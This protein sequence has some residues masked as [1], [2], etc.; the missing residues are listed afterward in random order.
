MAS[1]FARA[2]ALATAGLLSGLGLAELGCWLADGGAFPHVNFYVTDP[3][4]G[5][6]LA[7]GAT[8]RL[9]YA[10][11][12]VTSL[13]TNARGFRGEDWPSAPKDAVLVLG[14]SQVFG[15]G[16]EDGDTA[17]ARLAS[18]TG[19]TVLNA[20]TPTWG[21]PEYLAEARTLVPELHPSTVVVVLNVANDLFEADRPNA[22]RHA[23]WD[24]WAVRRETAPE[25]LA[26]FPGR[27]WLMTQSHAVFAARRWLTE[28]QREAAPEGDA[29]FPSE[30]TATDLL[31]LAQAAGTA[32][33]AGPTE[34]EIATK[35]Q[36]SSQGRL[37]G[38]LDLYWQLRGLVDEA[39]PDEDLALQAVQEHAQ[40]GD[41][42]LERYAEEG[43]SFPVTADALRKGA[44]LRRNL[45]PRLKA[46]AEAHPKDRRSA[47]ILAALAAEQASDAS[48]SELG[49]R[50]AAALEPTT[51]VEGF[52]HEMQVLC[53][54]NH[55]ELVIVALPVD[56]QVSPAEW[57]KYGKDPADP[58]LDMAGTGVLLTDIV[59]T[60]ERAG[61]RGLDATQA[62]AAAEPGAFLDGDFHLT[63]KGHAALADAIVARLSTPAPPARPRAGLPPGRSRVPSAGELELAPEIT[64][65][66]STRDHCS[67]RQLREWL[68]VDCSTPWGVKPWA[69]LESG[70]LETWTA[71]QPDA[72]RVL[73]PLIGGQELHVTFGWSRAALGANDPRDV[74]WKS[75]RTATLSVT[76][77]GDQPEITLTDLPGVHERPETAPGCDRRTVFIE[78]Q[79]RGCLGARPPSPAYDPECDA[80]LACSTGTR[81]PL[82]VCPD[83]QVNAGAAGHCYARC[84]DGVCAEGRC[85]DWMGVAACM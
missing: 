1:S 39:E 27:S 38:E 16:V 57:A 59:T 55:A 83:D 77:T 66:G 43:R 13:R 10:G 45:R 74:P 78:Q 6:R 72:A 23:S 46:W 30:G 85:V 29:G 49:V 26:A 76:W 54:E 58:A 52:I 60:A 40:P 17:S 7:P 68:L 65:R 9:S 51:P 8:E 24:G 44:E 82:P 67:T 2:A 37:E 20:G 3:V 81:D 70:S 19:R 56:V 14:D 47:D 35:I 62:L 79:A 48:L 63:P 53:R 42:L 73:T 33:P 25:R 34:A 12:P 71:S 4:L 15:L 18:A 84:D 64:V 75:G 32:P 5:L 11:N 28:Q 41:I 50:V 36:D 61:A 22:E 69:K 21:P 80:V 31:P